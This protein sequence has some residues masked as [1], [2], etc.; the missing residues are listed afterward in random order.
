MRV[1][2][3]GADEAIRMRPNA[4]DHVL[5]LLAKAE[6]RN[7]RHSGCG[8]NNRFDYMDRSIVPLHMLRV[9]GFD[10]S[11]GGTDGEAPCWFF[12]RINVSVKIDDHVFPSFR[13]M[14]VK[15]IKQ[16]LPQRAYP[17]LSC[18]LGS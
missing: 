18:H 5:M 8:L 17:T 2:H 12:F 1:K 6:F 13:S 14:F 11:F 16:L 7:N 10:E 9:H 15:P 4:V 3:H